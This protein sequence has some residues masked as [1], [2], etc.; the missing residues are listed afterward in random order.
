MAKE[1]RVNT[2][3]LRT[4]ASN[5]GDWADQYQSIYKNII[6]IVEQLDTVWDGDANNQYVQKFQGFENDFL[7]LYALLQDYANYLEGAAIRYE[8]IESDIKS[9]AG[10]LSTGI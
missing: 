10:S 1:L 2:D 8:N 9:S 7:N 6:S 3:Q 4:M 5:V